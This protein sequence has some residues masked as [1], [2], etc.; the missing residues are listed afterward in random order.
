MVFMILSPPKPTVGTETPFTILEA[1]SIPHRQSI[2]GLEVDPAV[3]EAETELPAVKC[4]LYNT[5]RMLLQ[6]C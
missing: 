5:L 3:V 1:V 4:K 6:T 2:K